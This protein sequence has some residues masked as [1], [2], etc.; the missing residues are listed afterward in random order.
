MKE[1]IIWIIILVFG[2]GIVYSRFFKPQE[3]LP[4]TSVYER[5]I[6]SLNNEI[7]LNNKKMLQLDSLVDI[8][9]NM[10]K[11]L[12]VLM[13][14][15]I[16]MSPLYSQKASSDT[17][18]VPCASLKKAIIIKQE[19]VYCGAQLGFAR[20]S[21]S[22]L[23]EIITAKDTII[24]HRDS[25]I[26]LFKDNELKYKEVINNKDSIITTYGKE[27]DRLRQGKMIAYGVGFLSMLVGLIFGL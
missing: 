2:G 26:T 21:I 20:D 23:Q 22:A 4:D 11:I 7:E 19:R 16:A 15:L 18:C 5:R 14:C 17:C 25:T 24:F 13:L 6:D 9:E 8:Q 3:K 10:K 12:S 1:A 27:I